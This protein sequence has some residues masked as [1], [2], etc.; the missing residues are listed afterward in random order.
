MINCRGRAGRRLRGV[1]AAMALTA[2]ALLAGAGTASA[3]VVLASTDP[4]RESVLPSR[5]ARVTL[6]FGESVQ[7]PAGGLRVF[8]PHGVQV[9]DGPADHPGGHANTVSIGLRPGAVPGSYTVAWRA[10]SA[11]THPVSGAFTFSVG[12]PSVTPA[13][14]AA[15]PGGSF[16][17]GV[18]HGLVRA[19]AY[20]A[21][22]A[23]VGAAALLLWCWPAGATHS[24]PPRVA[25]GG[26]AMLVLAT[27]GTLLLQS[28]YGAGTGLGDVLD[29][30]SVA[31]TLQLPLGAALVARLLLLAFGAVYLGQLLRRLPTAGPGTRA[32]L[33]LGGAGIAVGIAA[34]WSAAG[35]AAVGPQP[36]IAF[37]VDVAHLV[38]MGV[39]LGGLL[40]LTIAPRAQSGR[41]DEEELAD[42]VTR[43]S[44]IAFGCVLVLVATGTY[45]SWRQLGSWSELLGTDYGR[46]LLLKLTAVAAVLAVAA[47]SR[48][49]VHATRTQSAT[50]VG[51]TAHAA[52]VPRPAMSV[53][54]HRRIGRTVLMETAIALVVLVLTTILVNT[55][56]GRMAH[57]APAAAPQP[58]R[59]ASM[60]YDTGGA[61]GA[62]TLDVRIA[63]RRTGPDTV[64]ITVRDAN[65]APRDPLDLDTELTL[66]QRR[67]GPLRLAVSREG[68]GLYRA[69]G[70]IPLP[71]AWQLALTVRTSDIDETTVRLPVT[72][73]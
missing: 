26:L 19:L 4:T 13:A 68:P 30:G 60:P 28:P 22:A 10:I 57:A 1:V 48:R 46:V 34:T 24:V 3:H 9:E 63:P 33:R 39:W 7:L 37:P 42:A 25:H 20:A 21:F 49:A 51:A 71:G 45:Q 59:Q 23:L 36:E 41:P 67:L 5:P 44:P 66:P 55:E 29:P 64:D 32:G 72:V 31:T 11:D 58:P 15:P 12:R 35:H 6:S 14:T 62:G 70:H 2:G 8:D 61:G 53:G 50:G 56:P 17:V 18:L 65:G 52:L 43:F 47:L 73:D 38:A 54:A 40:V 27:V 69:D 16:T